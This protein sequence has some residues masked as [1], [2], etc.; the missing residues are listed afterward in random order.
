MRSWPRRDNLRCVSWQFVRGNLNVA[1]LVITN[2]RERRRGEKGFLTIRD[3]GAV[4]ASHFDLWRMFSA[5]W[6][7]HF[8]CLK[9]LVETIL[10]TCNNIPTRV[11][12][13]YPQE[14]DKL[15]SKAIEHCQLNFQTIVALVLLSHLDIVNPTFRFCCYPGARGGYY[16]VVTIISIVCNFRR[17]DTWAAAIQAEPR[18]RDSGTWT[19]P[20][21]LSRG[22]RNNSISG[23][24]ARVSC[25]RVA[26]HVSQCRR[27][28]PGLVLDTR[29]GPRGHQWHFPV[30]ARSVNPIG[31][32]EAIFCHLNFFLT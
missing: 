1:K 22:T 5:G 4:L 31:P 8:V 28:S 14:R 11:Q 16:Y 29:M 17:G 12:D 6:T 23:H 9:Y 21:Q 2:T 3:K 19:P 26:G 25:T 27:R 30:P 10:Q 15:I 20:A 7:N 24:V 32:R 18:L 13:S